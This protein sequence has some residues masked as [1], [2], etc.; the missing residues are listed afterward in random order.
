MKRLLLPILTAV[1]LC[2]PSNVGAEANP[3]RIS[4]PS[5][6]TN[7]QLVLPQGGGCAVEQIRAIVRDP[8]TGAAITTK[9]GPITVDETVKI[10]P[11]TRGKIHPDLAYQGQWLLNCSGTKGVHEAWDIWSSNQVQSKTWVTL[12]TGQVSEVDGTVQTAPSNTAITYY[13]TLGSS[14]YISTWNFVEFYA[15]NSTNWS[16]DYTYCA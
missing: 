7:P 15:S 12:T 13:T 6:P 3:I 10:C 4:A 1:T 14:L 5:N 8:S 2:M 9:A 16:F 11:A